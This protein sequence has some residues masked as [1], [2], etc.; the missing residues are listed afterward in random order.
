MNHCEYCGV[1]RGTANN[2][3]KHVY[4]YEEVEDLTVEPTREYYD[5]VPINYTY[6]AGKPVTEEPKVYG[7]SRRDWEPCCEC[8]YCGYEHTNH[9]WSYSSKTFLEEPVVIKESHLFTNNSFDHTLSSYYF[10]LSNSEI[11]FTYYLGTNA[12]GGGNCWVKTTG[13]RKVVK[14]Y[15]ECSECGYKDNCKI[16]NFIFAPGPGSTWEFVNGPRDE[17]FPVVWYDLDNIPS[18]IY[19][20]IDKRFIFDEACINFLST[21]NDN[22]NI[23]DDKDLQ[24]LNKYLLTHSPREANFKE[25]V[26]NILGSTAKKWFGATDEVVRK[27]LNSTKIQWLFVPMNPALSNRLEIIKQKYDNNESS[28]PFGG[29]EYPTLIIY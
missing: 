13:T 23:N 19:E 7:G 1:E 4:K 22:E 15:R 6:F 27:Y 18:V 12:F 29:N 14:D 11:N 3:C 24:E 21:H 26:L 20:A 16:K 10:G 25:D 17:H 8:V 28:Y 9:N 5:H 2:G